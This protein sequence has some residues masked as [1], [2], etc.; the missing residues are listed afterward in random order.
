ML[1]I[2]LDRLTKEIVYEAYIDGIQVGKFKTKLDAENA[3][4]RKIVK[5]MFK[6]KKDGTI[7][8]WGEEVDQYYEDIKKTL[9]LLKDRK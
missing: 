7:P 1:R 6:S 4:N 8:P 5:E 3:I 2:C 9:E